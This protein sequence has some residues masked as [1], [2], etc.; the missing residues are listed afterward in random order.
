MGSS[1]EIV[2]E[3]KYKSLLPTFQRYVLVTLLF[4][5]FARDPLRSF[6][7]EPQKNEIHL[8]YLHFVS[9]SFLFIICEILIYILQISDKEKL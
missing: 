8:L 9:K 3:C 5:K 4:K 1:K 2:G 7:H 6:F